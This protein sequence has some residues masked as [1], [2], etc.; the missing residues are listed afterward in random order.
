LDDFFGPKQATIFNFGALFANQGF[1][2]FSLL[3]FRF[4]ETVGMVGRKF[5]FCLYRKAILSLSCQRV[6][7]VSYLEGERIF[8]KFKTGGGGNIP[9]RHVI[10]TLAS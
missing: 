10:N 7:K 1:E 4:L 9:N 2:S 6:V 8:L 5:R 3:L